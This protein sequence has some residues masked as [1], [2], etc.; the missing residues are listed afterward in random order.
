MKNNSIEL[1]FCFKGSRTYV[2]GPD[3]FDAVLNKIKK[4]FDLLKLEKI[5]YS[6]HNMLLTNANLFICKS[7]EKEDYVNINS[8]IAFTINTEKYYAIVTSSKNKIECSMEY[9]E[10]ILRNSSEIIDDKVIEFKNIL[11]DSLTEVIVSMNKY[12]LQTTIP[13]DGKWIVTQFEYKNLL[14][15]SKIKNKLIKLELLSNFNNKLTKSKIYVGDI[16]VGYLFFSL[17]TEK[18]D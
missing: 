13:E 17:I 7:F 18:K 4:D 11:D 12:F 2:Q 8:L 5:K 14:E 10:E 9:S 6:A 16:L 3:I 1:N 15:Y